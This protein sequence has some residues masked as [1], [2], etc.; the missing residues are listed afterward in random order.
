MQKTGYF[1]DDTPKVSVV[2]PVYNGEKYLEEAVT[3]ILTQTFSDFE[4]II[5][6][7]GST[8][9]TCS[10]AKHYADSDP[11][12]VVV[13]RQHCGLSFSLNQ[14]IDLARGEWIARM[15]ADDIALPDRLSKQLNHLQQTQADF[16]G[17]GIEYFGNWT[18]QRFYP[19]T[20]EA[21]GIQILFSVP[22][23]HPTALGKRSAF[24]KIRYDERI[25]HCEDYDFWQRAWSMKY[26]MTNVSD[27]I[28]RYRIHDYQVSSCYKDVRSHG[29]NLVRKRHWKAWLPE[30]DCDALTLI[31][32]TIGKNHGKT[33]DLMPALVKLLDQ[34]SGESKDIFLFNSFRTFCRLAGH[35]PLAAK[36]WLSLVTSGSNK[37]HGRDILR[38]LVLIILSI[39]RLNEN[40]SLSQYLRRFGAGL[41]SDFV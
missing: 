9:A 18:A 4:L 15:D 22:I 30:L 29:V 11:R 16:C 24:A 32:E 6:D 7:D 13:S 10:I 8:D 2:L 26:R 39:T 5:I 38:A 20:H 21:C 33:A 1:L 14:G 37:Y 12:I 3:S 17:G 25:L 23:A 31:V 34:C 36:N 28:L 27:I 41:N 35:D 40:S 19:N